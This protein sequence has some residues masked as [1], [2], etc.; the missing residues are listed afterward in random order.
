M[1]SHYRLQSIAKLREGKITRKKL[2]AIFLSHAVV[3][4]KKIQLTQIELDN[5]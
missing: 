2:F 1:G 5:A 4:K 3:H